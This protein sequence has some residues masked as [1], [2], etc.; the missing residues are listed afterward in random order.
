ME[1]GDTSLLLP[2]TLSPRRRSA[3]SPVSQTGCI[4][5][6]TAS[7]GAPDGDA[8][9]TAGT[10]ATG[11]ATKN[12][13]QS[14]VES[15]QK[16]STALHPSPRSTDDSCKA[17]RL[18]SPTAQRSGTWRG[19][20][21]VGEEHHPPC[22]PEPLSPSSQKMDTVGALTREALRGRA[23]PLTAKRFRLTVGHGA[24]RSEPLRG[25]R[26]GSRGACGRATGTGPPRWVVI[27][28]TRASAQIFSSVRSCQWHA[29]KSFCSNSCVTQGQVS[30]R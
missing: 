15:T 4:C 28:F 23:R 7:D 6:A 18:R 2:S 29:T 26:A 17:A 25:C 14:A 13:S 22:W 30:S 10:R 9:E 11:H 27:R 24:G 19:V 16:C 20:S 3:P 12:N 8:Y 21:G 1:Y 5:V